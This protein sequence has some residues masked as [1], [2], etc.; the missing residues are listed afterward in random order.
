M[1]RL[2]AGDPRVVARAIT[3]MEVGG[4]AAGNLQRALV[5]STGAALTVGFTGPPR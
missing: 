4:P 2:R 5:P 1:Q 3:I